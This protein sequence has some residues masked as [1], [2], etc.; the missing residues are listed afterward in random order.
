[1]TIEHGIKIIRD[2]KKENRFFT[3]IKLIFFF[4]ISLLRDPMV[5]NRI[6]R[7]KKID[8]IYPDIL[9]PIRNRKHHVG[10]DF[11]LRCATFI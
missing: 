11:Q 1:M 9:F 4:L 5:F 10:F 2:V 7:F 3:I 6:Q 8:N